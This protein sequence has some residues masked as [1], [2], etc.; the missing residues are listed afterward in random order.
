MSQ[1]ETVIFW[2]AGEYLRLS[3]EDG[4]LSSTVK[5]QSNSIENQG[6]FIEEYVLGKPEIRLEERYI[7][8]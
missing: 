3:K 5:Q 8:M 4:D 1:K 7:D 2:K 6:Q